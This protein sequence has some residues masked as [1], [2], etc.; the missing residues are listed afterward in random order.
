MIRR[1]GEPMVG[2][3]ITEPALRRLVEVFYTRV[4]ADPTLGPV[5]DDAVDD[6]PDHCERLTAFWSSVA[7]ASGRY[8]GNPMLMHMRHGKRIAPKM[9]DRW[10]Q[11]WGET[12]SELMRPD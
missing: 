11:I 3:T 8:K 2:E 7:L 5:F 12:T 4:R 10:L 6:W 1:M 9:F